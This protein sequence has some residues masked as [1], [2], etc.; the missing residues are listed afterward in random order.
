MQSAEFLRGEICRGGHVGARR[1]VLHANDGLGSSGSHQFGDFL[2]LLVG[3]GLLRGDDDFRA[4]LGER[5][6]GGAADG[7]LGANDQRAFA[8]EREVIR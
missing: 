2:E 4:G 3:A 7:M 8:F 5:D 1:R 6:G